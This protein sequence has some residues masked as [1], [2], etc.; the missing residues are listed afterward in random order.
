MNNSLRDFYRAKFTKPL[1]LNSNN[2]IPLIFILLIPQITLQDIKK[3]SKS[4]FF[5]SFFLQ[6]KLSLITLIIIDIID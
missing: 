3:Y 4:Q 2:K 5:K 6:V 1:S